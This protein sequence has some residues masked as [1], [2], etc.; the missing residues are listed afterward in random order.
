MCWATTYISSSGEMKMSLS[1]M[2]CAMPSVMAVGRL[3]F[4]RGTHVLV[5]QVLQQL[6][7]AICPLGEHGSAKG[8]HNLLDGDI[9][10]GELVLCRA[11]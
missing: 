10:A 6:E 9:L 8:L 5:L 2:T 11:A 1:E 4:R 7:L 3:C